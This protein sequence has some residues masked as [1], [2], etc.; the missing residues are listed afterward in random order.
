MPQKQVRRLTVNAVA[1][2]SAG[3]LIISEKTRQKSGLLRG[4]IG[5][6]VRI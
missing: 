6:S 5:F 4:V 3:P 1:G 2:N